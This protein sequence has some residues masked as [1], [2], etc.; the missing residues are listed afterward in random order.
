MKR[1]FD[2][3]VAGA[4]LTLLFPLLI[5]LALVVAATLGLPILFKQERVGKNGK[6]FKVLKF[7]TMNCIFGPKGELLSDNLRRDRIGDWLRRTS[8]DELPQLLNVLKGEMSLVG[9]RPQVPEV[10]KYCELDVNERQCVRPGITGWAQINGRNAIEWGRRFEHDLWYV[11][12]R[13]FWL[14]LKILFLTIPCVVRQLGIE[15]A[16]N[17]EGQIGEW[18]GNIP[19]PDAL[20]EGPHTVA[21]P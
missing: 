17:S 11:H 1:A 21:R 5:I 2:C 6:R 16:T 10:L 3:V 18:A 20:A 15:P 4:V 12:N 13:G 19:R 14:D 9:P 8:L 7:R